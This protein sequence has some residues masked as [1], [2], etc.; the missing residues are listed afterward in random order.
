MILLQAFARCWIEF[1][2]EECWVCDLGLGFPGSS[3]E[4]VTSHGAR[5][6]PAANPHNIIHHQA[7]H[8]ILIMGFTDCKQVEVQQLGQ[9]VLKQQWLSGIASRLT[10]DVLMAAKDRLMSAPCCSAGESASSDGNRGVPGGVIS[11]QKN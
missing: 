9:A 2:F 3:L 11:L 7:P 6:P 10:R 1:H 5:S 8:V 4:L